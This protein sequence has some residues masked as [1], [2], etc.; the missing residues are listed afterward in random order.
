[1]ASSADKVEA[2]YLY[3]E[4]N[5]KVRLGMFEVALSL[6]DKAISLDASNPMYFNNRASCLKRMG[7]VQDAIKQYE[8]ILQSFPEYG[9]ALLSIGSTSIEIGKYEDAVSAYRRFYFAYKKGQFAFNPVLGG[10]D[11]TVYGQ[12]PLETAILTSINYLSRDQQ[13]LAIQAIR[14]AYLAFRLLEDHYESESN[15]EKSVQEL[16]PTP[17]NN[18]IN[19][20]NETSVSTYDSSAVAN[21]YRQDIVKNNVPV[22]DSNKQEIPQS[23][24]ISQLSRKVIPVLE[25]II[26][27]IIGILLKTDNNP[28]ISGIG[29]GV[30]IASVMSFINL[31]NN[32]KPEAKDITELNSSTSFTVTDKPEL[33]NI[34]ILQSPIRY[35]FLCIITGGLYIY[36]WFYKHWVF[37]KKLQNLNII[38]VL[39]GAFPGITIYSLTK[40]IFAIAKEKGYLINSKP[41]GLFFMQLFIT[42]TIG[43]TSGIP[44][45]IPLLFTF[46]PTIY[47]YD[48]LTYYAKKTHPNYQELGFFSGGMIGWIILGIIIWSLMIIGSY[49]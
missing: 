5:V 32:T 28:F 6:Y 38:P 48:S 23:Q 45:L 34:L 46:Y 40:R 24:N 11:Q 44:G 13:A 3:N 29:Q 18:T 16:E 15:K 35:I 26:L 43:R 14:Q 20:T 4:G 22:S 10:I 49:N 17:L 7:R 1:M 30:L 33:L 12:D 2:E 27:P 25:I 41:V 9:K 37:I 8:Q 36:Y 42:M 19:E 39:C 31:F 47:I 21:Q